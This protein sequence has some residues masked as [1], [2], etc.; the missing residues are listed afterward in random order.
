MDTA[1]STLI[2]L[3]VFLTLCCGQDFHTFV[4]TND[5]SNNDI[6]LTRMV[7]DPN[8]GRLYVGSVNRLYKLTS[9]LET[10]EIESTGP[11]DDNQNCIPPDFVQCDST[12]VST[13]NINKILVIDTDNSQLITCGNVYRGSCETRDMD[14][15]TLIKWYYRQ[16][17]TTTDGSTVAIIAHGP[18]NDNTGVGPNVLYVGRSVVPDEAQWILLSSRLL[19]SSNNEDPFTI[20]KDETGNAGFVQ[21][22]ADFFGVYSDFNIDYISVFESNGFT[23]YV[24]VQ[25]KVDTITS[26][27][28]VTKI[29]QICQSCS[30]YKETYIDLPLTC[31]GSDGVDYN[32]AQSAFVTQAGDDLAE[33]MNLN[34]NDNKDIVVV[35][36]AK[37]DQTSKIPT[38][39]S[40][41]CIYSIKK[42][43]EKYL[44]WL[45]ICASD[46]NQPTG[47]AWS[48]TA[49]EDLCGN[50][51]LDDV[52]GVDLC[53]CRDFGKI[54][55]GTKNITATPCY[56][57]SD[58]LIT[59]VAAVSHSGHTVIFT[60]N[61]DGHLKK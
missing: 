45:D 21:V 33:V 57:S 25:P 35:S 12:L 5:P 51:W 22:K 30:K 38:D 20:L 53:A 9:D 36:F 39:K 54:T 49:L 58:S 11:R 10:E 42:I 26:G 29:V 17:A 28:F 40:A 16:V 47:C 31:T 23:Y 19:P 3:S 24:S 52:I 56:T 46:P 18:N 27:P 48:S 2:F 1:K 43:R 13:N 32:L 6:R 55:C 8:N 41:V 15:L 14:T 7:L 50:T 4:E 60:G 34:D 44:E 37:A 59:A 61:Q